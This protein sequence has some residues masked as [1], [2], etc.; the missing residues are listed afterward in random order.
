MGCALFN[1]VFPCNLLRQSE[2]LSPPPPQSQPHPPLL[3]M[4]EQQPSL[5]RHAENS[6]NHWVQH[7]YAKETIVMSWC[8]DEEE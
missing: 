1:G 2:T 7:R 5:A 4:I 3:F 8:G 6:K